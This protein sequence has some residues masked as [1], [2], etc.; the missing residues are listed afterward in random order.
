V[1]FVEVVDVDR[2]RTDY[3]ALQQ[4]GKEPEK[5]KEKQTKYLNMKKAYD[6]LND[7]LKQDMPRLLSDKGNFYTPLFGM[8][9]FH[10]LEYYKESAKAVKPVGDSVYGFDTQYVHTHAQVITP[11]DVS[12]HTMEINLDAPVREEDDEL[13]Q[14]GNQED[15]DEHQ[16]TATLQPPPS[17]QQQPPPQKAPMGGPPPKKAPMGGP[18]P[19][20]MG[21]PPPPKKV[22]A[23]PPKKMGGPPPPKKA[24]PQRGPPQK[25]A[26]ALYPFAGQDG[27]ELSFNPGDVLIIHK[28][29]GDWWDAELNGAK[30]LIPGNYVQLL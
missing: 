9:I 8:L 11:E 19:K 1:P 2:Y 30:G 29:E 28:A 4:K 3:E 20:K 21:G 26:R 16:P 7:E 10:E 24:L 27:S 12:A 6:M 18:P 14:R 15:E 13:N 5:V 23:P 22:G 25:T 17:Y